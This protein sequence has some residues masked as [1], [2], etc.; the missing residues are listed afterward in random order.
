MDITQSRVIQL[1]CWVELASDEQFTFKRAWYAPE[2]MVSTLRITQYQYFEMFY[3]TKEGSLFS[4]RRDGYGN[5]AFFRDSQLPNMP[6]ALW[7][8][9]QAKMTEL[10]QEDGFVNPSQHM[11]FNL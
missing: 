11:L 8:T 3:R 10:N 4:V 1:N 6:P 7:E 9:V 5:T 2:R